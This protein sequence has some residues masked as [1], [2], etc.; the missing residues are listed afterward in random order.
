LGPEAVLDIT[1]KIEMQGFYGLTD[2]AESERT[3][4]G[5]VDNILTTFRAKYLLQ[6]SAGVPLAGIIEVDA[7]QANE[8]GHGQFGS[9]FVHFARVLLSVKERVTA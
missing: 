5:I 3:F 8:I 1:H 7:A 2:A 4:Q 9:N 6:D